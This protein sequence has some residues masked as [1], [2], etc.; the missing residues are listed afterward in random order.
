MN[1]TKG[2]WK[3]KEDDT[4]IGPMGNVIAECCGYSEP[5][6]A[7]RGDGELEEVERVVLVSLNKADGRE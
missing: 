4:V 3:V 1:Y 5:F 2:P 6:A 7:Y